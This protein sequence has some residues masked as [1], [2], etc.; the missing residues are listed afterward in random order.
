MKNI[1]SFNQVNETAGD[2]SSDEHAIAFVIDNSLE[3]LM[4]GESKSIIE[5]ISTKEDLIKGHVRFKIT[6]GEKTHEGLIDISI[7]H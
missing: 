1:K 3:D 6:D 7:K 4:Q 5:S 2:H